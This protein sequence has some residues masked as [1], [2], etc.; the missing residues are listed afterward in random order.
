MCHSC[1]HRPSLRVGSASKN[2]ASTIC[3]R[4]CL[5][6]STSFTANVPSRLFETYASPVDLWKCMG[7]IDLIHYVLAGM[8]RLVRVVPFSTTGSVLQ[9]AKQT[10]TFEQ[11]D[12]QMLFGKV[13]C[14]PPGRA[15][16]TVATQTHFSKRFSRLSINLNEDLANIL[17]CGNLCSSDDHMGW[18][19]LHAFW[20][21]SLIAAG[22]VAQNMSTCLSC[23]ALQ[24]PCAQRT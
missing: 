10:I 19:L 8:S 18:F 14:M 20:A 23:L 12:M 1:R 21:K 9:N 16:G 2:C 22:H 7:H 4:Q 24:G 3:Y 11:P 5:L 15:R 6:Q 13:L 17:A